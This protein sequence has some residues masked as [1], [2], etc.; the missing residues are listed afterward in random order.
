MTT[1]TPTG[2]D[3]QGF[4]KSTGLTG[5][6]LG[7]AIGYGDAGRT[8]RALVKGERHGN[9]FTLSG[10]AVKSLRYLMAL[11]DLVA[12]HANF[13]VDATPENEEALVKAQEAAIQTLPPRLQPKDSPP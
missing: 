13:R 9:P 2:K 11:N 8:V 4:M 6:E 10:T 7:E 3:L 1:K 5:T 12:A